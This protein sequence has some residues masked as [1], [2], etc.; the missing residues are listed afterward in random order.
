MVPF[1][2]LGR[3]TIITLYQVLIKIIFA[4]K[5]FMLFFKDLVNNN[6]KNMLN[7][8][9]KVFESLL[10]MV[11][12]LETK[13]QLIY[14]LSFLSI[15]FFNDYFLCW[16]YFYLDNYWVLNY[17][18]FYIQSWSIILLYNKIFALNNSI[19]HQFRNRLVYRILLV[20]NFL[21]IIIIK[22]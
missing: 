20:F 22:N 5:T 10:Y 3:H 11:W 16:P 2:I 15:W 6:S 17:Q 12:L 19:K 13:D 14:F 7:K 9:F 1:A 8:G 4:L 18:C 21:N